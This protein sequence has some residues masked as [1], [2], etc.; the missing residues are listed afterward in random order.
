MS[1][2]RL[3]PE[4]RMVLAGL[5]AAD[6]DAADKLL[7]LDEA[8]RMRV[9]ALVGADIEPVSEPEQVSEP[10]PVSESVVGSG[11]SSA[12]NEVLKQLRAADPR[13]V[14]GLA[15]LDEASRMRVIA[16]V[17]ADIEPVSEP[18]QV[19]EPEP[20]SE[21][22]VGS[23]LSSA[24]N[25]VLKQLRAADP[26]AVEGLAAL[27]EASRMRVI[28][29]VGA[30]TEPTVSDPDS[31]PEPV[32]E[33]VVGSGLSS[34]ENEVLKQLRAADPRAVEGLAALDEA[35][36][37][38]VIAL[39]GADTEPTVSDPDSEPEPVSDPEPVMSDPA[40]VSDPEP[41]VSEP[42][43]VSGDGLSPEENE[44]L[45]RLRAGDPGA[46]EGLTALDKTSQMRVVARLGMVSELE[47]AVFEP[48]PATVTAE[49]AVSEAATVDPEPV[50]EPVAPGGVFGRACGGI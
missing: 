3:S 24:E 44:V 17:G 7:T 23:G 18:E 2:D 32:S 8:S 5:R 43:P 45:E 27:D 10:E 16:L 11:L 48:E 4:E 35:G 25:E 9:I 6:P 38:R 21:S 47:P 20:V 40:P 13:A 46:A 14:E 29:L 33:S 37:M 26:R 15:A 41:V 39:V 34:A 19:S 1:I 50:S 49:P 30:D 28:A 42:A 36:R 31:E 12:E 22:V